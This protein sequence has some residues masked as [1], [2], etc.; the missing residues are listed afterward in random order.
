MK[1]YCRKSKSINA[2]DIPNIV[3]NT[4]TVQQIKEIIIDKIK[5]V[6]KVLGIDVILQEKQAVFIAEKIKEIK[7]GDIRQLS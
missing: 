2:K 6:E 5:K 4:Y 1:K 7:N 3:F